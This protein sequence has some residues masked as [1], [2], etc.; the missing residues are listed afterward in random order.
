MKSRLLILAVIFCAGAYASPHIEKNI[1]CRAG[2]KSVDLTVQNDQI[3]IVAD[4]A[5][6]ENAAAVFGNEEGAFLSFQMFEADDKVN[7]SAGDPFGVAF[8]SHLNITESLDQRKKAIL[9]IS[10]DYIVHWLSTS[11]FDGRVR[12]DLSMDYGP[13]SIVGHWDFAAD[14]CSLHPTKV[15]MLWK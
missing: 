4:T 10:A 5:T 1:S 6:F 15:A 13:G 11:V 7:L 2:N 12:I 8:R 3:D 14:E 9:E